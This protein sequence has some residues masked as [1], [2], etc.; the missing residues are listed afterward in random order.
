MCGG[1]VGAEVVD[2][3]GPLLLSLGPVAPRCA[4]TR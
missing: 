4:R 1:L 2:S 3:T